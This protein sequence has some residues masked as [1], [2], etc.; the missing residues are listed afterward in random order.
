MTSPGLFTRIKELGEISNG[1][2]KLL[3]QYFLSHF[4]QAS[5]QNISEIARRS[6]T[7]VA[8][9]LRFARALGFPGFPA[10]RNELQN[11]LLEKLAPV[12]RFSKMV[13]SLKSLEKTL[14]DGF[15]RELRNL[16]EMQKALDFSKLGRVA[17]AILRARKKYILGLRAPAG[18]AYI[19]AFL[20][21]HILSDVIPAL[22]GE[23]RVFEV[24]KSIGEK[25]LLV[26]FSYP[27]YTKSS[28]AA[29][30]FAR[31]RGALTVAI[32]DSLMSP[33][34]QI[35]H[36]SLIA[37]AHSSNFANSHTAS[38]CMINLLITAISIIGRKKTEKGLRQMEKVLAG[39]NFFLE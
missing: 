21:N 25:D 23:T 31:E 37:P 12:E 14:H 6:H 34:S 32:T 38:L 33:A 3:T 16:H 10:L 20:L 26:V 24:M 18:C 8:T 2:Q 13:P 39:F 27:R 19:L 30:Q 5:F 9:V 11:I 17:R 15:Q 36:F 1:K 29:L 22:E 35:A 7:S 28:L 4:E